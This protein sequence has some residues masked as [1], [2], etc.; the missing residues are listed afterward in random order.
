MDVLQTTPADRSQLRDSRCPMD[1]SRSGM[2]IP[3]AL[4]G[5][6]KPHALANP[7]TRDNFRSDGNP[8]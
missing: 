8:A 2:A 4:V 5:G 3:F 7:S 1:A 6:G